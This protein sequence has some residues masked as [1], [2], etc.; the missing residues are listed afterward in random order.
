MVRDR[1]GAR[2]ILVWIVLFALLTPGAGPFAA[3]AEQRGNAAGE[4]VYVV[5]IHR[6]IETGLLQFL[7]R[8][9]KEAEYANARHIIL[10]MNTPGGR[11]DA[12]E[13]IGELVRA[14]KVPTIAFIHGKASSAGSY[15]ALNAGRIAMEPGSTIGA[16]A[17][18][19][20]SGKEIENPK[21]IS[22]WTGLMK[23]AAENRKRN[24]DIAAGMVDKNIV[25]EL[26]A[27]G[28][29]KGRGEILTLTADEALKVGY[30]EAIT[31]SLNDVIAFI[32]AQDAR[33]VHFTPSPAEKMAR[34]LTDPVVMTLLLIIGVAGLAIELFIPGF[35]VPG[36]LGLLG[37]GLYF[38]GQ[39]AAGFAGVE[40]IALFILGAALL[41][42][43]I[44]VPGFGLFGIAG[45]VCLACGI[46]LAA[47]DTQQAFISLGI[48]LLVA[49]VIVAVAAKYFG[50]RGL[51]N[52]F[53]LRDEQKTEDGYVSV[54][55]R[56]ALIGRTGRALTPLRP[57]GTAQFGDERVDVVTQGEYISPGTAVTVI[58][59]EGARIVVRK[60]ENNGEVR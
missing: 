57:S 16:A 28:R 38:F 50:R 19:D 22:H 12:A 49:V 9:F 37:F 2:V 47:Y 35:G 25:V 56:S 14:S 51:W 4:P 15:I 8:A 20:L 43:E 58:Q 46:V 45:I 32:G 26:P 21:I 33:I 31:P 6:T 53:I 7:K 27:L 54:P 30:A 48:A 59:A 60:A 5:P 39:Y 10:D 11:I 3:A 1:C 40:D 44:F 52:R 18:V 23:A 17:V 36:V 34:F 55:S 29:T 41:A 24:P 13:D 42:V